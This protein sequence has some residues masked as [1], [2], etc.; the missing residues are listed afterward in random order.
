MSDPNSRL[1]FSMIGAV[2]VIVLVTIAQILGPV[3]PWNLY[4]K[5]ILF[6]LIVAVICGFILTNNLGLLEKKKDKDE[7]NKD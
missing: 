5:I 7:N 6:A 1:L 2:A 4:I 3:L